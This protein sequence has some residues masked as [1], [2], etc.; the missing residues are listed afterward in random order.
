MSMQVWIV[1]YEP[2]LVSD[3]LYRRAL[4]LVDVESQ[5]RIGRYY[6][7]DDACRCLLGRLLPRLLLKQ[8]GL[9]LKSMVFGA[10]ESGKPYIRTPLDPSIAYNIS[11]DN[12]LVA[13]A[14][15]SG[16][17]SASQ[18]G[19]DV[20]QVKLPPRET[21]RN[22]VFSFKEQLT[23]VEQRSLLTPGLSERDALRRFFLLWTMKEAYTKALGMGLG[24]DFRRV[25]YN[26]VENV[27]RIDGAVP[28]G[29]EFVTFDVHEGGNP[30]V[31]VTARHIGGE[32]TTVCHRPP[33]SWLVRAPADT[34]LQRAITELH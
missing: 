23:V 16:G 32:K 24:F 14:F 21:F 34:L 19:V 13:M 27:V 7:R 28:K 29:W 6:R 25:E 31:G 10:S 11:H 18:V 2:S 33:G 26:I 12:G 9:P 30:Y 1:L 3:E 15:T 5:T 8:R 20:M 22:F 17:H 4:R